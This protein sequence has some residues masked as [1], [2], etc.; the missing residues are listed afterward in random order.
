MS[1]AATISVAPATTPEPEQQTHLFLCLLAGDLPWQLSVRPLCERD[2]W[3]IQTTL[4]TTSATSD[5]SII[6]FTTTA[7]SAIAPTVTAIF[8]SAHLYYNYSYF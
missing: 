6:T 3:V 4:P 5:A 8:I 7:G 1:T 2:I